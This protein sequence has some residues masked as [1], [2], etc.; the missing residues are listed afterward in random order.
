MPRIFRDIG[1]IYVVA[2]EQSCLQ[3]KSIAARITACTRRSGSF[4]ESIDAECSPA[5]DKVLISTIVAFCVKFDGLSL[6]INRFFNISM[7]GVVAQL[8]I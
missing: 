3:W 8:S 2:L 4:D 6:D 1:G 7:M 5:T